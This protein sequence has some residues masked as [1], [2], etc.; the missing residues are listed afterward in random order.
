[1][2]AA[3]L[4]P[5]LPH[6]RSTDI[7][8]CPNMSGVMC[9]LG[10]TKNTIHFSLCIYLQKYMNNIIVLIFTEHKSLG[11]VKIKWKHFQYV[12][13]LLQESSIIIFEISA[14]LKPCC[15]FTDADHNC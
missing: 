15:V 4:P 8:V 10:H 9:I 12:Q 6:S 7:V 1:M 3:D 2:N 14:L 5:S 11:E 13:N